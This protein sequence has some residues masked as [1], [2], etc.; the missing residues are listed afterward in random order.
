M[1]KMFLT[2]LLAAGLV[3]GAGSNVAHAAK[4][5]KQESE[6]DKAL[7]E[8]YPDAQTK[9]T[10]SKDINGVKV[11]DVDVKTKQGESNA[12][13]TEYGDFLSYGVPH[14]YSAIRDLIQKDVGGV[15]KS[16]P[17]DIEMFRVTN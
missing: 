14:E 8:A 15:F 6:V 7:K 12:Q 5:K 11:Y 3:I 9:I 16:T 4:Q 1:K 2:S 13:V 17:Q 10:G